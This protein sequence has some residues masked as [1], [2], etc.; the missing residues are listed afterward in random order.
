MNTTIHIDVSVGFENRPSLCKR[1]AHERRTKFA[2]K[3]IP[4]PSRAG[5]SCATSMGQFIRIVKADGDS[6]RERRMGQTEKGFKSLQPYMEA[7][8]SEYEANAEDKD[9]IVQLY[10]DI[11]NANNIILGRGLGMSMEEMDTEGEDGTPALLS[12][13]LINAPV[14]MHLKRLTAQFPELKKVRA[15]DEKVGEPLDDIMKRGGAIRADISSF[16]AD[17]INSGENYKE[18]DIKGIQNLLS[19]YDHPLGV[20]LAIA[21]PKSDRI[22]PNYTPRPPRKRMIRTRGPLTDEGFESEMNR[23]RDEQQRALDDARPEDENERERNEQFLQQKVEE[24]MAQGLSQEEALSR[25]K[26]I[27]GRR[28]SQEA[29]RNYERYF[30]DLEIDQQGKKDSLFNERRSAIQMARPSTQATQ[31]ILS[32]VGRLRLQGLDDNAAFKSIQDKFNQYMASLTGEDGFGARTTRRGGVITESVRSRPDA[33]TPS[34]VEAGRKLGI[35]MRLPNMPDLLLS[36]FLQNYNDKKT[37]SPF[38]MKLREELANALGGEDVANFHPALRASMSEEGFLSTL[39]GDSTSEEASAISGSRE[40]IEARAREAMMSGAKTESQLVEPE[41]ELRAVRGERTLTPSQKMRDLER[42]LKEGVIDDYDYRMQLMAMQLGD[43]RH[44][45]DSEKALGGLTGDDFPVGHAFHGLNEDEIMERVDG[46]TQN[47][48]GM[49]RVMR[50]LRYEAYKYA[51]GE[52]ASAEDKAEID[53]KIKSMGLS[54]EDILAFGNIDNATREQTMKYQQLNQL[55]NGHLENTMSRINSRIGMHMKQMEKTGLSDVELVNAAMRYAENDMG[56]QGYASAFVSLLTGKQKDGTLDSYS[57]SRLLKYLRQDGLRHALDE[58]HHQKSGE[59]VDKFQRNQH[60]RKAIEEAEGDISNP[61]EE[62]ADDILHNKE[63]CLSCHEDRFGN[64]TKEESYLRGA[65]IEGQRGLTQIQSPYAQK[66]VVL[67]NLKSYKGGYLPLTSEAGQTSLTNILHHI[68]PDEPKYHPKTIAEQQTRAEAGKYL[69]SWREDKTQQFRRKIKEAVITGHPRAANIFKKFGLYKTIQ[70]PTATG[71]AG[72]SNKELSAISFLLNNNDALDKYHEVHRKKT[73]MATRV[74][75]IEDALDFMQD[76]A[77]GVYGKQIKPGALMKEST[78]R[79]I[80]ADVFSQPM[81]DIESYQ[82]RIETR[83][84]ELATT[85]EAANSYK[86]QKAEIDELLFHTLPRKEVDEDGIERE[87]RGKYQSPGQIAEINRRAEELQDK[88][89][90]MMLKRKRQQQELKRFEKK[91][92]I[93]KD[94]NSEVFERLNGFMMGAFIR[95]GGQMAKLL[96][97]GDLSIDKVGNAIEQIHESMYEKDDFDRVYATD[98]GRDRK[99]KKRITLTDRNDYTHSLDR[100]KEGRMGK[101]GGTGVMYNTNNKALPRINNINQLMAH[102]LSMGF[103]LSEEDIQNAKNM[104]TDAELVEVAE[105]NSEFQ[106]LAKKLLTQEELAQLNTG[107]MS[108]DHHDDQ[109]DKLGLLSE[110]E[111]A[112]REQNSHF[113]RGSEEAIANGDISAQSLMHNWRE[114]A[115]TLCGTCHGHA[116][117]TRD[118]AITYLRHRIP[119]L[120]DES[121]HGAKMQKYIQKHLRPR[122]SPSFAHHEMADEMDDHE[123]EQLAC[124]ACEHQAGHVRGGKLSN[125]IC[126]DCF[127]HGQRDPDNDEHIHEGHIHAETGEMMPGKNHHY[128]HNGASAQKFDLLNQF[129]LQGIEMR[130]SGEIPDFLQE[131]MTPQQPLWD[132]YGDYVGTGKYQSL[133]EKRNARKK[134]QLEPLGPFEEKVPDIEFGDATTEEKVPEIEFG[135]AP[136]QEKEVPEIEFG[137]A[138]PIPQSAHTMI[139]LRGVHDTAKKNHEKMMLDRH[140][141]R[142]A[143]VALKNQPEMA[144]HINYL[145]ASIRADPAYQNGDVHGNEEHP[146]LGRFLHKLQEIAEAHLVHDLSDLDQMYP[147]GHPN[148]GKFMLSMKE[149]NRLLANSRRMPINDDGE[150]SLTMADIYGGNAPITFGNY[151]PLSPMHGRLLTEKEIREGLFEPGATHPPSPVTDQEIAKF[152]NG[153]KKIQKILK[154]RENYMKFKTSKIGK[155]VNAINSVKEP[156]VARK[157]TNL[158]SDTLDAL[159]KEFGEEPMVNEMASAAP[160]YSDEALKAFKEKGAVDVNAL[161]TYPNQHNQRRALNSLYT[162]NLNQGIRELW[163][164]FAIKK[165]LQT[166]MTRVNNP[167][168][169]PTIPQNLSQNNFSQMIGENA[170]LYALLHDEAAKLLGY[171]DFDHFEKKF[172]VSK[173]AQIQ[174]AD[175]EVINTL[176]AKQFKAEVMNNANHEDLQGLPL[177]VIDYSNPEKPKFVAQDAQKLIGEGRNASY[178]PEDDKQYENAKQIVRYDQCPNWWHRNTMDELLAGEKNKEGGFQ[179]YN[180]LKTAYQQGQLPPEVQK[181]IDNSFALAH[182]SHPTIE[183]QNHNDMRA[184]DYANNSLKTIEDTKALWSQQGLGLPP[185]SYAPQPFMQN[186]QPA[187]TSSP[188]VDFSQ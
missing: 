126:G 81:N 14:M 93:L 30:R 22:A 26:N 23:L 62:Y 155:L 172:N 170:S 29:S 20:T 70:H 12:E 3:E 69:G 74:N 114:K 165:A 36:P 130:Q 97:E 64:R 61:P 32:Q 103:P 42:Q 123:H 46:F 67:P 181:T 77:D 87:V 85:Q 148:K 56:L 140:I 68:Y 131:Q 153:N 27:L 178:T 162:Q 108:H 63:Q 39:R 106:E 160:T 141:N 33:L 11:I 66:T 55:M 120:R 159:L 16:I 173:D 136:K 132:V 118:E 117:L 7:I 99:N 92:N 128:T 115:P 177:G 72:M 37:K 78:R 138:T 38:S 145:V 19:K 59:Q 143:N 1:R 90:M 133:E 34:L 43:G 168:D 158:R 180:E 100:I 41:E 48:I 76:L 89:G 104:M 179:D 113:T 137:D 52:E 167:L 71:P 13:P 84:K 82:R 8:V 98:I 127:G 111:A 157:T 28:Q 107:S 17:P 142:L 119:E 174:N 187:A 4:L 175:G 44:K 124:P 21:V 35:G 154:R 101:M 50:E 10:E 9:A 105:D 150:L 147:E 169:H 183:L 188:E 15:D 53:D 135:D 112:R 73:L 57:I 121:K 156:M 95:G 151:E 83:Q 6:R 79:D 110:E 51:G 40:E 88:Y 166:F 122:G 65:T 2:I 45:L 182:S 125:G 58:E 86:K 47:L 31:E 109:P 149:R 129:L 146:L 163:Q 134:K 171:D 139:Q 60:A 25:A 102:R 152:F 49:G 144:G 96:K 24:G 91:M 94:S 184:Y 80:L 186:Q 176:S 185:E 75:A 5:S 164:Q 116:W 54:A 18:R 161:L